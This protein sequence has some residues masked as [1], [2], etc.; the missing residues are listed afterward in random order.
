MAAKATSS[1]ASSDIAGAQLAGG[2][3][4]ANEVR[5]VST[6]AAGPGGNAYST[7]GSQFVGLTVAGKPIAGTPAPNTT[8]ALPGVGRVVLNEQV[9]SGTT[10]TVNMVHVYVTTAQV[11]IP[12]NTSIIA[13]HAVSGLGPRTT[14]ILSGGAYAAQA[15]AG[16]LLHVGA[17]WPVAV[18]GST[19]GQT[20]TNSGLSLNLPEVL[21]TGTLSDTV[22][23]SGTP[24]SV[25]GRSTSTVQDLSLLSG[26]VSASAIE[27]AANVSQNGSAVVTTDQ[28]SSFAGLVVNG[29]SLP[30]NVAANTQI[31]VGRS[32]SGCIE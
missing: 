31:K 1:T 27:A 7:T 26:L 6:T 4:S 24:G 30:A 11:G 16:T 32:R 19:N 14:A 22:N 9:R 23:A 17:Q 25:S 18:C 28:G 12:A 13:G 10:L 3:V 8:I 5:A 21:G 2:L 20:K 15:S 29:Q